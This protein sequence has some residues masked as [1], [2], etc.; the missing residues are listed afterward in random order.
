LKVLIAECR[1]EVS[2]FN[3]VNTGMNDFIIG[4]GETF[5]DSHRGRRTEVGGALE[6]FAQ[7]GVEVVGTYSAQLITS[8]GILAAEAWHS[9]ESELLALVRASIDEIDG[10][11]CALHG[12]MATTDELDPE[13]YLLQEIRKISGP[14]IPIVASLD[15]HGILTN[16]MLENA[17][18]FTV[19]QTYPHEDFDST[20][21]RAAR[22]LLKI[23]QNNVRPVTAV[24]RIPALVR[25][26]EMITASGKIQKTV[27]RCV[28]LEESGETLSAAMI[29]SNPF[30][31]VPELACAHVLGRPRGYAGRAMLDRRR[32]G[33][34]KRCPWHCGAGRCCRCHQLRRVR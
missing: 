24:V 1:Q 14:E 9:M 10:I 33:Y 8:G 31:D 19:Y 13:G 6:V 17:N 11:Y 25:G 26:D 18:A 3:P 15:L 16:R 23:L 34:G 5:L 29:W 28:Q 27:G 20:G 21:R 7:A 12:A 30:T 4:R 22:L 32:I 2:S